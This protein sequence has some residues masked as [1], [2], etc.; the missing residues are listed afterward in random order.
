MCNFKPQVKVNGQWAGNAL[1]FATEQEARDNARELMGRWLL[2]E[3]FG[4][5]PTEDPV[6]YRWTA[7][8]LVPVAESA[9]QS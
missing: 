6:N 3:E 9:V 1:V 2:V 5:A 7:T 4:S 8:G